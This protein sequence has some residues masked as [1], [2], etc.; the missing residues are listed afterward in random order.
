MNPSSSYLSIAAIFGLIEKNKEQLD[1]ETYSLSQTTLESVFLSF[2]KKQKDVNDESMEGSTAAEQVTM[3]KNGLS[4]RARVSQ[5]PDDNQDG[6]IPQIKSNHTQTSHLSKYKNYT[7]NNENY[8][9]LNSQT[10]NNFNKSNRRN[11]LDGDT[12]F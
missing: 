5:N 8:F 11:S 6:G 12:K 3:P 10:N 9:E 4:N 7:T 1:L 2:A